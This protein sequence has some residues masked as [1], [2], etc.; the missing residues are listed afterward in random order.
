[1]NKQYTYIIG[2]SGYEGGSSAI[3]TSN[4]LYTKKQ[5]QELIFKV[6]KEIILSDGKDKG[7]CYSNVYAILF[8]YNFFFALRDKLIEKHGFKYFEETAKFGV[9]G[10]EDILHIPEPE[11]GDGDGDKTL[12]AFRKYLFADKKVIE[13][14]GELDAF[15]KK[16]QEEDTKRFESEKKQEEVNP[17][18]K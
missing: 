10:D 5:L 2:S 4:T 6:A 9:W 1:M 13:K 18:T 17:E 14:I 12:E 16:E 8:N 15:A 7:Y 3:L 11:R